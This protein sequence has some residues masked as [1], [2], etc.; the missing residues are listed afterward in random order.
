MSVVT[1]RNLPV[2]A[3]LS[4]HGFAQVH[5]GVRHVCQGR[6]VLETPPVFTRRPDCTVRAARCTCNT[7]SCNRC[8]YLTYNKDIHTRKQQKKVSNKTTLHKGSFVFWSQ[9]KNKSKTNKRTHT[10][11]HTRTLT[12]T[13]T[14]THTQETFA[15]K[16]FSFPRHTSLHIGM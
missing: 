10:H 5:R 1:I 8:A 16:Y 2:L 3:K 12:H 4:C 9:R 14:H 7:T 13:H 15:G 6:F 11:T